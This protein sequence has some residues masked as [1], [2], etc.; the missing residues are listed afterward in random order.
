MAASSWRFHP[1]KQIYFFYLLDSEAKLIASRRVHKKGTALRLSQNERPNPIQSGS[2]G[3]F[4]GLDCGALNFQAGC[5]QGNYSGCHANLLFQAAIVLHL[6][7]PLDNAS[8]CKF[9]ATPTRKKVSFPH[10]MGGSQVALRSPSIHTPL[11]IF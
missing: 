2:G 8:Q 9:I 10:I 4:I 3:G 1:S 11:F 6:Y 7:S 5:T